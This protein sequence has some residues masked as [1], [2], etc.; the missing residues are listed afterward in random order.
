MFEI[1][2]EIS[3]LML[4]LVLRISLIIFCLCFDILL[5]SFFLHLLSPS[6]V[7]GISSFNHSCQNHTICGSKIRQFDSWAKQFKSYKRI[8]IAKDNT[9][10]LLFVFFYVFTGVI[11]NDETVHQLC[12]QAVSQVFWTI[13]I[14][15][16]L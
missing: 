6:G 10:Q 8:D 15:I 3:V 14:C 4:L 5:F 7:M 2:S 1:E 9:M 11:M 16:A 13:Q 12:K